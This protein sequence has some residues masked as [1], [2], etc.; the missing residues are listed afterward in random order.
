M[1]MILCLVIAILLMVSVSAYSTV[2]ITAPTS[3]EFQSKLTVNIS[4]AINASGFD[5]LKEGDRVNVTVQN[6]SG[7]STHAYGIL[8]S[9]LSLTLNAT[10][11]NSSEQTN[12]WNFTATLT[13]GRQWIKVSFNNASRYDDGTFRIINTSERVVQIDLVYDRIAILGGVINFSD[14][15]NINTSG[16]VSAA[17]LHVQNASADITTDT[18]EASNFGEIRINR[19]AK[20][21]IWCDGDTW[22]II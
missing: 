22:K 9:S 8:A 6:H 11:S 20:K 16:T 12:F 14:T 10:G 15:G 21:L 3:F 5:F 1:K 4:A 13:E 19:T 17:K 18:C 2:E 7:N